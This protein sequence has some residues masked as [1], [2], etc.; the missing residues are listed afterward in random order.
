M[1]T[2]NVTGKLIAVTNIYNVTGKLIAVTN[3]DNVRMNTVNSG[4]E[5][6]H[7]FD[8]LREDEHSFDELQPLHLRFIYFVTSIYQIVCENVLFD[9]IKLSDLSN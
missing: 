4:N 6:K 7:R 1:N 9:I 8:E 3:T 5:V 2:Y